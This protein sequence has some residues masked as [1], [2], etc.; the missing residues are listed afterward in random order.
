MGKI[1]AR[2]V[3]PP[4][5]SGIVEY[6]LQSGNKHLLVSVNR[7]T[8]F[9]ETELTTVDAQPEEGATTTL[10][11]EAKLL[12]EQEAARQG[13]ITYRISTGFRSMKGWLQTKGDEIFHWE[14]S[15]SPVDDQE[16][17]IAETTIQP[18]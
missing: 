15:Y 5:T 16:K 4:E 8:S 18:T 7:T 9:A 11:K 14:R 2:I 12:L 3:Y 1:E 17:L 10:Y 13:P 6:H